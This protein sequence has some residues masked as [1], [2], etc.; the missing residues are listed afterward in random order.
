MRSVSQPPVESV[1]MR[2]R[3]ITKRG[4]GG[5]HDHQL[6]HVPTPDEASVHWKRSLT[7]A[8]NWQDVLEL[9]E[10]LDETTRRGRH[11]PRTA[12]M[13][14]LGVTGTDSSERFDYSAWSVELDGLLQRPLPDAA[15][16][17]EPGT[18]EADDLPPRLLQ[19]RVTVSSDDEPRRRSG[20]TAVLV[21]CLAAL[22]MAGII[23]GAAY[24]LALP[25]T[26]T[27]LARALP[28]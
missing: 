16:T 4:A 22:A 9:P 11:A 8:L 25:E 28:G 3:L 21:L 19:Q 14:A 23:G 20:G 1:A 2:A 12:D 18:L 24:G 6:V 26:K 15:A 27:I 17:S 5:P 7:N 13:A 10:P